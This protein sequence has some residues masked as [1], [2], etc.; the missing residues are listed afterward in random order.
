[1][2]PEKKVLSGSLAGS[3]SILI[4]WTAGLFGLDVPPEIAQAFTVLI[5]GLAS[6][7][8]TA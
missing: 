5:A 4:A 3:A 1:M 2:K 8:T 6:Y 7:F